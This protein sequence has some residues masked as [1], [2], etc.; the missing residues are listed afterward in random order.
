MLLVA[1]ESR[2][3]FQAVNRAIYAGTHKTVFLEFG[4]FLAVFTLALLH[5]RGHHRNL[6]ALVA[7]IQIIDNL[8][9][10][11]RLDHAATIGAVRHAKARKKQTVMVQNF[12]HRTHRRTRVTVHR[13]LVNRN[14][15]RNAAHAF[16]LGV[17]HAANELARIS[18]ERLNKAALAFLEHRI[19]SE[20]RLARTRHTG[21]HH[22]RIAGNRKIHMA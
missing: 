2:N 11:L 15:R 5:N 13:L 6:L 16:H 10:R 9:H 20:A 8:V 1:H 7:H 4:Q 21:H 22:D 19:E 17:F 18:R 12:D 14:R 3:I